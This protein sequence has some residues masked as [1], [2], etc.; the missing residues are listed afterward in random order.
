MAMTS[1]TRRLGIAVLAGLIVGNAIGYARSAYSQ[2]TDSGKAD[3]KQSGD[4]GGLSRGDDDPRK[5]LTEGEWKRVDEAVAR[6]LTWLA[7]QQAND[8]SF[9]SLDTGQPAVTSLCLMAFIANGHLP[10]DGGPYG[11][12][13]QRALEY[14]LDS[15]KQNGL[16]ARMAPE[17][18]SI[19]RN[20]NQEVGVTTA[21]N[22]AISALAISEMYGTGI[23]WNRLETAITEALQATLQMQGWP[24]NQAE[25][26]G[27]WR[28][29]NRFDH[30]DSDVSIT[31]WELMFLRS[32]RNAGFDVPKQPVDDAVAYIRRAYSKKY[33]TITYE[34]NPDDTRSRAMAG[35][36]ILAL[37]HGGLHDSEEARQ[38]GEWLLRQKFEPYNRVEP[39]TT[40]VWH[41]DRYHYAVFFACQGTYQLGG[42]YWKEFFPR[43]VPTLLKNQQADGSWAP[44]SHPNDS[45]YGNAYT[46]ALMVLSLGAP[47]QLLPI[48]QR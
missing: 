15:Q 9:P 47:N 12:R 5:V 24:K 7:G 22:H 44:E 25:D 6:A 39:F 13:L 33:E 46:T 29:I 30:W 37:A 20:V 21:Y 36:G 18:E 19:D 1:G 3:A 4:V 16:I 17:G 10:S 34:I 27:G 35:A 32:A 8:G 48:F 23:K 43:I 31:G 38:A 40:I 2:S 41:H 28:Y 45:R 14:V 26:K 42:H 11:L